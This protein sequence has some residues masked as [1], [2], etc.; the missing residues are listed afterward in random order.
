MITRN[1]MKFMAADDVGGGTA[2]LPEVR[3]EAPVTPIGD[4]FEREMAKSRGE[5]LKEPEIKPEAAAKEP[6]PADEKV[7]AKVEPAKSALDA[8]LESVSEEKKEAPE[9]AL[10]DLPETLPREGKGEHWAKARAAIERHETTIGQQAKTIADQAKQI[11]TAKTVP[12]ETVQELD[13][14]KKTLD[15][16]K[17]AIVAANIELL[18]E[19]RAKYIE[20]RNELVSETTGK[21]KSYGG[22]VD[23]LTDALALPESK[24]RSQMI[25]EAMGEEMDEMGRIK[26][27]DLINQIDKLDSERAR[28]LKNAQGSWETYQRKQAAEEQAKNGQTEAYKRAVFD[29]TLL[30]LPKDLS[31]LRTVDS[32][33]ADAADHNGRAQQ[34][35]DAAWKLLGPETTP[36]MIVETALRAE[37]QRAEHKLWMSDRQELTKARASLK[38]YQESEPGFT[39]GKAPKPDEKEKPAEEKYFTA[40]EKLQGAEN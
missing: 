8:V 37:V 13:A 3:A 10:K 35:R 34:I 5:E 4:I 39:G 12:P 23:L 1:Q 26:V 38:E 6:K 2:V 7:D 40:L 22:N 15:G 32:S 25:R 36:E 24:H 14:L 30:E 18:P 17:D 31:L 29:K 9:S 11:E 27:L 33:F 21:M 20:G 19:Y 28:E 16:Y